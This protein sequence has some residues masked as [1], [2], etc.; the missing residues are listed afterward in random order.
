M[1]LADATTAA[2]ELAAVVLLAWR[3]ARPAPIGR[4]RA[5]S[6]AVVS[7]A[8]VLAVTGSAAGLGALG[9]N[10]HGHDG[11]GHTSEAVDD[12]PH[13]PSEAPTREVTLTDPDDG[14]THAPG[15]SH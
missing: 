5:A 15:E 4:S 1:G 14:H 7:V 12:P 9:Q 8:W 10:P 13:T 2:V 6:V 3:V 11:A